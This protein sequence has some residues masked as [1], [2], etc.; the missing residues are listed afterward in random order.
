MTPL[1]A[2]GIAIAVSGAVFLYFGLNASDAPLEQASEALTGS[3]SN[4]TLW[5]IAG[6]LGAMIAGIS[7]AL[8]T[9]R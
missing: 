9:R 2:L 3:Y 5:Y 1:R 7:L 8:P 4:H 6:G